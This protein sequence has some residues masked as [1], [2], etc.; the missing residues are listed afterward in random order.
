[1]QF[2]VHDTC[3]YRF[4]SFVQAVWQGKYIGLAGQSKAKRIRSC[5][6]YNVMSSSQRHGN[7]L[8]DN[9]GSMYA[10]R[11]LDLPPVG[12]T[13]SGYLT[14]TTDGIEELCC[15]NLSSLHQVSDNH[16]PSPVNEAHL[17]RSGST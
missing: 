13:A 8:L 15:A 5:S 2:F 7:C 1:M 6:L 9:L 10:C 16:M 17:T 3:N 11:Y 12:G 4:A 14:A